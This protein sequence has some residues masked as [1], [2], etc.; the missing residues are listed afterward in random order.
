MLFLTLPLL[1]WPWS[2][3]AVLLTLALAPIGSAIFLG[4]RFLWALVNA[5]PF[6]CPLRSGGGDTFLLLVVPC[7]L[8][9][10]HTTQDG[11]LLNKILLSVPVSCQTHSDKVAKPLNFISSGALFFPP[12]NDTLHFWVGFVSQ[13]PCPCLQSGQFLPRLCYS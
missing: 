12:T 4:F 10:A 3:E 13:P 7:S 11:L 9:P 5:I 6:P 8:N 2:V 1:A